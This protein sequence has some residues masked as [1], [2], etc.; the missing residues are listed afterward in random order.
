MEYRSKFTLSFR[1]DSFSS[2][3]L[4][5]T[6]LSPAS[7]NDGMLA[8]RDLLQRFIDSNYENSGID[9]NLRLSP[10]RI[11]VKRCQ[12]CGE[13][14]TPLWRNGPHGPKT[15]CNACGIRF[16]KEEKK[17]DTSLTLAPPCS[18]RSRRNKF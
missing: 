17:L 9:V 14:V 5:S 18:I 1:T 3:L 4:L 10:P 13:T 16:R 12:L 11:P 15:A 6:S 8:E 2:S 7:S